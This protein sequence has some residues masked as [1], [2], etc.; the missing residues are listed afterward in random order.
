[1]EPNF[2]TSFIPKKSI[3][4]ERVSE[5]SSFGLVMIISIFILFCTLLV[6]GGLYFYKKS[7]D[8]NIIKMEQDLNLAKSRFEP[9]KIIELQLLDKR[10]RASSEVLSKHVAMTPIFKA[11]QAI[12]MKTVRFT[13]FNSEYAGGGSKVSIKM[14]GIANGYRTVAL[15]ADLFTTEKNFIDPVFSNLTLDLKGNVLFDLN[16]S[17]DSS[18]VNYKQKLLTENQAP[19]PANTSSNTDPNLDSLNN[20]DLNLDL[21]VGS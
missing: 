21:N 2:Q 7:I 17:V 14:S 9:A 8:A 12:T 20:L 5:A 13:K 6:I 15:Q 11:L 1:M 10:L 4:Q 3:V 19:A 18:F 16:F